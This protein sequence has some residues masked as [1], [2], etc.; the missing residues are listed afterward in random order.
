[1]SL[2]EEAERMCSA[3]DTVIAAT[4]S[5]QWA[6][7]DGIVQTEGE[8]QQASHYLMTDLVPK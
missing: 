8:T 3:I 6:S 1:M 4:R 7:D 2:F 5:S